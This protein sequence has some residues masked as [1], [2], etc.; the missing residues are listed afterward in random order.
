MHW[1][2]RR[3]RQAGDAPDQHVDESFGSRAAVDPCGPWTVAISTAAIPACVASVGLAPSAVA[4]PIASNAT[5]ATWIAPVRSAAT[6]RS[7]IAIP[8]YGAD[9]GRQHATGTT[10]R[11]VT[12]DEQ[13]PDRGKDRSLM[14]DHVVRDEPR[15]AGGNRGL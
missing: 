15:K 8:D 5:T 2:Q 7:P 14:P 12:E 1:Q 3:Y 4:A 10:A 13:R 6:R 11:G 9:R